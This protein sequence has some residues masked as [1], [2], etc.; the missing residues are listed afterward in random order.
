MLV[1]LS[2][3]S[4]EL[5]RAMFDELTWL[6]P[7]TVLAAALGGFGLF[8]VVFVVMKVW[9]SKKPPRPPDWRNRR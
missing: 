6:T 9:R 8:L 7:Y 4:F 3:L 2:F 1:L 5:E